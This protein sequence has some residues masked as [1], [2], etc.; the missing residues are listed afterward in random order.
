MR[1][2]SAQAA[3]LSTRRAPLKNRT[4]LDNHLLS[5]RLDQFWRE[6][7]RDDIDAAAGWKTGHQPHRLERIIL[8]QRET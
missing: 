8:R 7:P 4:A 6:Q 5:E 1:D 2:R 3:P